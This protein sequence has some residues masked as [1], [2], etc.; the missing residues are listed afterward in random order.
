MS[1]QATEQL[2]AQFRTAVEAGSPE[3]TGLLSR[4]KAAV[5]E[6]DSL[7]PLASNTPYATQ[8]RCVARTFFE[9]A[10]L[11]ALRA[12]DRTALHRYLAQLRPFYSDFDAPV[13]DSP[14]KGAITGLNLLTL[15]T[16]QALAEFH[17]EIE[18]L[19]PPL[20]ED[21]HVLFALRLERSLMV[22]AYDDVTSLISHPPSPL[23]PPLLQTLVVTVRDQ[24]AESI[25][26]SYPS[27]SR[28]S[29][30][31]LLMFANPQ[32]ASE[33]DAFFAEREWQFDPSNPEVFE[34]TATVKSGGGGGVGG[35]GK[36]KKLTGADLPALRLIGESLSYATELERIV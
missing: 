16:D 19:T 33:A 15:L 4:C 28:S 35:S 26:T 5:L 11:Y 8:E 6:F 9:G 1:L 32:Q 13:S 2:V 10:V 14:L 30:M 18:L 23:Y 36:E 34:F 20:T 25:E 22:G 21:P 7:P 17:S 27:L 12:G 3:A 31:E 24:I 29:A